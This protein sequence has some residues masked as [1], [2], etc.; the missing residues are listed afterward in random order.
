LGVRRALEIGVFTGY[1]ALA[2]ALELPADGRL[3]ACDRSEEWT[4]VAR[5]HWRE[6]GVED[7]IDLRLGPAVETLDAL[8]DNDDAAPFDFA[9]IDAD[10]GAYPRYYE[11]CLHLVR[12]GGVIAIDNVFWGGSVADEAR[13][14]DVPVVLRELTTTIMADDRV[15]PCHLP[16]GDGVLLI[17]KR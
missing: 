12:A 1:S 13:T 6:A 7:R 3:V 5:R 15:D 14:D 16:L 10:K 8:I 2:V 4:A 9:F 17:R 11:Q